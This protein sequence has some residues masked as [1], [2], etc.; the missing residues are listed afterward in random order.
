MYT[1]ELQLSKDELN[2][3]CF[4]VDMFQWSFFKRNEKRKKGK[5]KGMGEKVEQ[6]EICLS[7]MAVSSE[8]TGFT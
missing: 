2:A 3:L 8:E 7:N 5:I 6:F 1:V 4:E